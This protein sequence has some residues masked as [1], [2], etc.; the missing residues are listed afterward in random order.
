MFYQNLQDLS[1]FSEN[2]KSVKTR[3]MYEKEFLG[4]L[5]FKKGKIL[6]EDL[7]NEKDCFFQNKL[8]RIIFSQ[9]Y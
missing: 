1:S 8:I 6:S 9:A 4:C 5:I 7:Q 3:I 2:K